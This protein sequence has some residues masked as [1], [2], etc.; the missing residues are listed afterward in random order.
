MRATTFIGAWWRLG[1]GAGL[2]LAALAAC[3]QPSQTLQ[4]KR[5]ATPS[6]QGLSVVLDASESMCGY[7]VPGGQD[8][9]KLARLVKWAVAQ[10]DPTVGNRV[11]LL[12]QA[13]A[14][15][16]ASRDLVE[17]PVNLQAAAESLAD[18]PAKRGGA[19]APFDGVGSMLD[20]IFDPQARTAGSQAMVLVTDG[21]LTDRDRARFV[22]AFADW[23]RTTRQAGLVPYAGLAL[24]ESPFEGRYFPVNDPSE[25]VRKAGY[26]LPR[27]NRPIILAWFARGASQLP[28]IRE[29]VTTVS[30]LPAGLSREGFAI[31]VLPWPAMGA[32]WLAAPFPGRL[33]LDRSIEQQPAFAIRKFNQSRSTTVVQSCLRSTVGP[34]GITVEAL[35]TCS[36][37]KPLFDGVSDIVATYQLTRHPH[38]VT[39]VKGDASGGQALAW[40]LS[41]RSFG[42]AAFELRAGMRAP[43]GDRSAYAP[44]AMDSDHCPKAR[45]VSANQA[46]SETAAD[47]ACGARLEGKTYQLDLL[48]DQLLTRARPMADELLDELYKEPFVFTFRVRK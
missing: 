10:Q 34:Q 46:A 11:F 26:V 14:T 38:H 39:T 42:D 20:L 28:R 5:S 30:P 43:A 48:V 17:A 37:G 36:D 3:A 47:E 6:Y 1:L 12:R 40:Q 25:S 16:S 23:S 8:D 13:A 32:G 7:F 33:T 29:L 9:R 44:F 21:Q 27:H 4:A 19:C 18:K 31:H 41:P 15:P 24:V 2:W 45:G 22:Q 35:P